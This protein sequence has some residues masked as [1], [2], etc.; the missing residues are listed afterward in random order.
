MP[1]MSELRDC[2]QRAQQE[3]SVPGMHK[4]PARDALVEMLNNTLAFAGTFE[5]KCVGTG[6]PR[7]N[8]SMHPLSYSPHAEQEP[9]PR[10]FDARY[11]E[12]EHMWRTFLKVAVSSKA[13]S[14]F[15]ACSVVELRMFAVMFIDELSEFPRSPKNVRGR[16]RALCVCQQLLQSLGVQV[17]YRSAPRNVG[18]LVPAYH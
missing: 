16:T 17:S 2:A 1:W 4:R 9:A 8:L 15:D 6:S 12:A 18:A 5:L 10:A 7:D 13:R 14:H 11:P 3:L